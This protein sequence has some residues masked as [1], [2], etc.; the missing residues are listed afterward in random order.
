MYNS[1]LIFAMLAFLLLPINSVAME[2]N[3]GLS[4]YREDQFTKTTTTKEILM[5]NSQ[6]LFIPC[7][8]GKSRYFCEGLYRAQVTTLAIAISSCANQA[9]TLQRSRNIDFIRSYVMVEANSTASKANNEIDAALNKYR[10][11]T[12]QKANEMISK[13]GGCRNLL[14]SYYPSF[15]K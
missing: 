1:N 4:N 13:M 6:N 3:K 12:T 15:L 7:P 14:S 2:K 8:R 11:S 5:A 10:S 9:G